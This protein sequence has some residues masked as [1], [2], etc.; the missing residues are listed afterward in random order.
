MTNARYFATTLGVSHL[1]LAAL[2]FLF[3]GLAACEKPNDVPRLTET[4][5]TTIKH[6]Q[7][8]FDELAHRVQEIR[9]GEL[10]ALEANRAYQQA[11]TTLVRLRNSLRQAKA[12]LDTATKKA[13]PAELMKLNDELKERFESDVVAANG[14]LASVEGW[15]ETAAQRQ[16]EV[17]SAAGTVHE[18]EPQPHS[19]EAVK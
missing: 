1:R 9:P 16:G 2:S 14:L 8:E 15:V 18:G 10:T 12:Q 4:A 6:F 17:A 11:T 5:T 13:D 3:A 19:D 7:E